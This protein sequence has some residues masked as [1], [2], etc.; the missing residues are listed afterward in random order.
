MPLRIGL[1][2]TT[3][4]RRLFALFL[5][6]AFVPAIVTA[7]LAFRFVRSEW[8]GGAEQR[9][10]RIA[11]GAGLNTL[12]T[13]GRMDWLLRS[14]LN[15]A[16]TLTKPD[17]TRAI[18]GQ[19]T[20]FERR[21]IEYGV[22]S[23]QDQPSRVLTDAERRHLRSGKTLV[24]IIEVP[25]ST[26]IFMGVLDPARDGAHVHWGRLA[27][28]A[29]WLTTVQ[30]LDGGERLC[31]TESR[32][33]RALHCDQAVPDRVRASLADARGGGQVSLTQWVDQGHRMHSASW[34]VFLRYE[35][36]T[37]D[38][39][40]IVTQTD[41][42]TFGA[43]NR[44]S[45]TFGAVI[46]VALL[47]VFFMSHSQIRRSTEP[48]ERLQAG[49]KR[50]IDGDFDTLVEVS[51]RDEYAELA[52][53]FNTMARAVQRQLVMLRSLDDFSASVM[54]A[55]L[56]GPV[57]ESA[58]REMRGQ[59][60][61]CTL[62][63]RVAAAPGCEG[64][65]VVL[66]GEAMRQERTL[67]D[68]SVMAVLASRRGDRGSDSRS[69]RLAATGVDCIPLWHADRL[70]GY[71]EVRPGAQ[72]A[73]AREQ[74]E[75]LRRL[76][77]RLALAIGD[78][79]HVQHLSALSAGTLMAFARAIDANSPWTAGHS[80]RVTSYAV[81]IGGRLGLPQCQM[82][83]LRRGGLLHDIGK[84]GVP[85]A[86]LDKAGPLTAAERELIE[87]HPVLGAEI[88]D[89]IG[90]FEDAIPIVRSHHE[91]LDG[92]G[93]PDG[94]AGEEIP[95][96][97]RVLAVA[98]VFD[99]LTSHR[100]Y[101]S[102]LTIESA[103]AIIRHDIGTHFDEGAARAF[104]QAVQRGEIEAIMAGAHLA[105]AGIGPAGSRHFAEDAA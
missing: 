35:Y 17:P 42:A 3:V 36:G 92:S 28:G 64:M 105:G 51:S 10:A 15:D 40:V 80:E 45:A 33:G 58:L 84:I 47:A 99:A 34:N 90:T 26:T 89:P 62:V 37:P 78:V 60:P 2:R 73:P 74:R 39:Q 22:P 13:L 70:V 19:F 97:A 30:M 85:P 101:R 75:G 41:E 12:A 4:G 18:S 8:Q 52:G 59:A 46:V 72:G 76:A 87:R 55:R 66:A 65:T 102:A 9:V 50:L 68:E 67:P 25:G 31:V 1:L 81:A 16:G 94:L 27:D 21:P 88:L 6:A 20:A 91:R 96:L 11:K 95:Y 24:A 56:V 69:R 57:L 82:D 32:E 48:L 104:L 83:T 23:L 100:P 44:F 14:T 98:D 103:V 61:G 77:E 71:V 43:L 93:Y 29:V 79:H 49:T 86:V 54:G 5:L 63:A 7:G 53:S 38:W